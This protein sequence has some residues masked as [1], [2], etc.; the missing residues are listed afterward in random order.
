MGASNDAPG[1]EMYELLRELFPICRSITGNGL[2]E[3]LGILN[4]HIPLTLHEVP[5]G[6]EAFDWVI[7][8]E[9]NI[10]DAYILDPSGRKIADF[11]ESNLHVV[12]YSVPVDREVELEELQRHL[13]SHAD[14]PDAIPYVTSYYQERWGF[15]LT[16]HQRVALQEG[17]YRVFID[18]DLRDG[19]MT[20]GECLIPGESEEEILLSTDVCH[21]SLANNELSGPVVTTWLVKWI[22]AE[23]RRYS[24]R[25]LFIPETIGSLYYL[26]THLEEMKRKTKAG[27]NVVCLGDDRVFSFLPSR[28]GDTLADRVALKILEDEHPGFLR[29]SYLDRGSDER[30]YCSPGVALP[31]V[32]VMRSMYQ[33]YPEYH[34]SLDDLEVVSPAGLEGGFKAVR[35]CLE[36]LERNRS[37]RATT[38]GEPQLGRRGLY[39]TVSTKQTHKV[40]QVTDLTNLLAYADGASDLID[41]SALINVPVKRLYGLVDS[42]VQAG[43]LV[44]V[45]VPS[46]H[47][48]IA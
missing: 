22:L 45:N 23:P 3:T 9:W 48:Q 6:T 38:L 35:D 26:S 47:V 39:P 25:I 4:R 43:L 34:T 37:Y 18:S 11:K 10:R 7:P 28:T 14:Q 31:V 17:R 21:P 44:E 41:L 8:R 12:G 42:A 27:F 33:Q 29:Y 36:L 15:C 30:Q 1:P 40:K 19:S 32:S 46:P 5:S 2:R 13:Y 20:F 16:H 24:Y